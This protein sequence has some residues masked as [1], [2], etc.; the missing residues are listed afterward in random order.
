MIKPVDGWVSS[1]IFSGA[2]DSEVFTPMISFLRIRGFFA[3]S[4]HLVLTG[5]D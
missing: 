5:Q 1:E 2:H 4:S 3:T